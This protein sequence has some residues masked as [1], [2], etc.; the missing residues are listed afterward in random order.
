[1]SPKMAHTRPMTCRPACAGAIWKK[2]ASTSICREGAEAAGGQ[3]AARVLAVGRH[4]STAWLVVVVVV[5]TAFE[6][7]QC[8]GLGGQYKARRRGLP[9]AAAAVPA[10]GGRGR[11]PAQRS[12]AAQTCLQHT[13]GDDRCAL[14]FEELPVVPGQV[15]RGLGRAPLLQQHIGALR[16]LRGPPP[17]PGEHN[18]LC[19]G[20]RDSEC[21]WD[22][23]IPALTCKGKDGAPCRACQGSL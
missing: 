3:G 10:A 7:V 21:N 11:A 19:G 18:W 1:M 5:K 20:R 23:G 13:Y 8:G 4:S 16:A 15:A 9:D 2:M 22:G 12:S 6:T 17:P 14:L